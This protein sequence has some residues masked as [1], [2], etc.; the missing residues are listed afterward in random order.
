MASLVQFTKA[1]PLA[2]MA[3]SVT[4]ARRIYVFV[5]NENRGS[6]HGTVPL[7]DSRG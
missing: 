5:Q 6:R 2:V 4:V 7:T 1:L 3:R